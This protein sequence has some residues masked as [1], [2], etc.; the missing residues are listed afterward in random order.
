MRQEFVMTDQSAISVLYNSKNTSL[1]L[2]FFFN[3]E[4]KVT[5][6]NHARKHY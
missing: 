3:P 5:E 6:G 2:S 4:I 1:S